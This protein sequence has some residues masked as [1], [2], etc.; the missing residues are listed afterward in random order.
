M[1]EASRFHSDTSAARWCREF[2][3]TPGRQKTAPGC[4]VQTRAS[5]EVPTFHGHIC[6]L[7]AAAEN[8][9]QD[10]DALR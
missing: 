2:S 3:T 7:R 9:R 5:L 10:A 1:L 4:R 8:L 6:K